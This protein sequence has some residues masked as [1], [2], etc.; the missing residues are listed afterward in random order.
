MTIAQ[1]LAAR[2]A[3]RRFFKFD[4]AATPIPF[5]KEVDDLELKRE[6]NMPASEWKTTA[7]SS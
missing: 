7:K 6:P 4:D 3:L 5:G 1:D 2:D